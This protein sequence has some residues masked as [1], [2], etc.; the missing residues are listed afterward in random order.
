[1]INSVVIVGRLVADPEI[2]TTASGSNVASFRIAH[3]E[4]RRGANGEK[5]TLY[6]NCTLFGK[7][8]DT[9]SRFFHKGNLIGVTGKL[10]QRTYMNRQN[11]Q[12]TTTE[13][14]VD[15]VDF[16]EG[17]N[18]SGDAAGNNGYTP[19]YPTPN[20]PAPQTEPASQGNNLESLDVIEDDLPF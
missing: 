20:E 3:D 8:T 10:T 4:N 7:Q 1:M 12:V 13:I 9:L 14:I 19:D 18:A 11:V 6:I 17:K 5:Q 15:R 16:V 2:R